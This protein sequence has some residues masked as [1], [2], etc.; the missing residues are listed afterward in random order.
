M[1]YCECD[2]DSYDRPEFYVEHWVKKARKQHRCD[3]CYGPIYVGEGYKSISGKWDRVMT[4][5]E[6]HL[7]DEM[8]EWAKI[9]M[10]CFCSN[11]FGT[12]QERCREMMQD[13]CR[14]VPDFFYEWFRRV[15]KI[16]RRKRSE[17]RKAKQ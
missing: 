11:E 13:V 5:R 16:E 4:F 2:Y 14:E 10:P 1:S 3:E 9:S 6:C 12:L 17:K 15:I 8:R 7:C